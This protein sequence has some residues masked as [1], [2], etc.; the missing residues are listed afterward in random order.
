MHFEFILVQDVKLLFEDLT[1]N[2]AWLSNTAVFLM[3]CCPK[4]YTAIT[5]CIKGI[6]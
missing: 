5:Y 3:F 2:V 4:M 1:L 6:H